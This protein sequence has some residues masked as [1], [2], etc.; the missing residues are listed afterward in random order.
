MAAVASRGGGRQTSS[1]SPVG[2]RRNLQ[3]NCL[4]YI[5]L[6]ENKNTAYQKLW[7]AM[8]LVLRRGKCMKLNAN[9]KKEDLMSITKLPS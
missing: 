9:T 3:R 6:N 8:K 5:D 1:K 2:P 7:D 4:K